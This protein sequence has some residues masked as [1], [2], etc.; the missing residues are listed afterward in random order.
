MGL[1]VT[2]DHRLAAN[3]GSDKS[4]RACEDVDISSTDSVPTLGTPDGLFVGVAGDVVGRLLGDTADHT[5][6]LA[7]GIWPLR[8]RKI[9]KTGTGASLQLKYL[10]GGY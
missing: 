1:D 10:Y 9:T 7:A 2:G 3:A 5:F 6:T 4:A 8:F